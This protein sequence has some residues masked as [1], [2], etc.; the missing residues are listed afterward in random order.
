MKIDFLK[1]F[2]KSTILFVLTL[3][4]AD[5]V[6]GYTGM[7]VIVYSLSLAISIPLASLGID[8]IKYHLTEKHV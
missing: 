4:L 7:K 8:Y 3:F 6:L 1:L 5:K 2:I